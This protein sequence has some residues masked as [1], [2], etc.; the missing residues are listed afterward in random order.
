[1]GKYIYDAILTPEK[2][3]G[4]SV[5][6]PALPGCFTYGDD[7]RDA[8]FM[9]ADAMKTWIAS[10]LVDG[11]TLPNYRKETVPNGCEIASIFIE[12]DRTFIV[13]GPVV[14]AAQ[15]AREL[16]VSPGRVTHM[17]DAGILEGYRNGRRTFVTVAS[18]K[19]RMESPREAGRPKKTDILEA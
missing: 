13:E 1:M 6:V 11:D 14:S 17:I 16:K 10:A 2:E 5:E 12:V 18:I 7:Y 19:A 4:Y 15:A 8:V 3:G 9:A